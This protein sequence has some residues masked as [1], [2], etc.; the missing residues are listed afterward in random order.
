V[1]PL[2]LL[3]IVL[4]LLLMPDGRIMCPRCGSTS[5]TRV[6][7]RRWKT[8]RLADLNVVAR[9]HRCEVC[10]KEFTT[11]EMPTTEA[12]AEALLEAMSR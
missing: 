2:P 10:D 1:S 8:K 4:R 7:S 3:R 9:A 5:H 11:V 6:N 12:V